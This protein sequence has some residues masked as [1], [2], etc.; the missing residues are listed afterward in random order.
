MI[1][2]SKGICDSS[3]FP[4]CRTAMSTV[5]RFLAPGRKV[6]FGIVVHTFAVQAVCEHGDVVVL[7]AADGIDAANGELKPPLQVTKVL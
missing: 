2:R 7:G 6:A 5:S 4:D 3:L 1:V